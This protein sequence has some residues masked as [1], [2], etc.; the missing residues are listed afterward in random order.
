MMYNIIS[1][2][3]YVYKPPIKGK[4]DPWRISMSRGPRSCTC[5]PEVLGSLQ[6]HPNPR[7]LILGN[8]Q[9]EKKLYK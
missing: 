5:V 6:M 2:R 3:F 9:T 7:F 8:R 4:L 1:Q